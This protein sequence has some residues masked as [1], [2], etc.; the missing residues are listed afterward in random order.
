MTEA[1]FFREQAVQHQIQS[2]YGNIILTSSRSGWVLTVLFALIVALAV[3]FFV[4]AGYTKRETVTGL[5]KPSGGLVRVVAPQ[6]AVV[7][8]IYV[9]V[10]DEVQ[11]GDL[12]FVLGDDRESEQGKTQENIN[13]A[14]LSQVAKLREEI[15]ALQQQAA[16]Q[17]RGAARKIVAVEGEL[18]QIAFQI[19]A[20]E[21]RTALAHAESERFVTLHA[22]QFVS[23]LQVDE[24]KSL[25]LDLDANL[26]QLQRE[27]SALQ[28]QLAELT[29]VNDNNPLTTSRQVS[30]RERQI[31]EIQAQLAQGEANRQVMVRAAQSGRVTALLATIGQPVAMQE[32][33]LSLLPSDGVLEAELY[34][35]TRAIGFV[36][37]GDDVLLRYAAFPYEKYGQKHGVVRQIS[38]STLA[39]AE[40]KD[41]DPT[42]VSEPVYRIRVTLDEDSVLANRQRLPLQPG[43]RL[44]ASLMLEHRKLYEWIFSPLLELR[45]RL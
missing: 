28:R 37:E 12:L 38:R 36:Q 32:R 40:L 39:P 44:D 14:L 6:Q 24:R 5:I 29:E 27:K 35:P 7:K 19:Q 8:N 9:D 10:G 42:V 43:M 18:K 22:Q 41:M 1:P 16:I 4:L 34:V 23:R 3:A 31:S 30:E 45:G 21:K 13:A 11:A 2:L 20:V 25:A 33:M 26:H 15:V 17:A